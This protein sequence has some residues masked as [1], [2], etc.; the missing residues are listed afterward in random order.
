MARFRNIL[1]LFLLVIVFH[2]STLAYS[3]EL[4][5]IKHSCSFDGDEEDTEYYIDDPSN[6]AN[7]I[8]VKVMKANVLSQNFIIKSA[9][10]KN[11]RNHRRR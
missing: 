1:S 2:Y 3:Q 4:L 7:Q 6:E 8:V 5:Q 9:N 11:A 10:C